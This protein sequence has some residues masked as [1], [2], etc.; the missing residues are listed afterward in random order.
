MPRGPTVGL[1][2]RSGHILGIAEAVPRASRGLEWTL[3][4]AHGL[5]TLAVQSLKKAPLINMLLGLRNNRVSFTVAQWH[6]RQL[7]PD[8]RHAVLGNAQTITSFRARCKGCAPIQRLD[9]LG[10]HSPTRELSRQDDD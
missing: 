10:G 5:L 1:R 8:I 7:D 3:P 4:T 6:L 2:K 9:L